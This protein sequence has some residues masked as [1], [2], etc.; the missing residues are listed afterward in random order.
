M[1]ETIVGMGI[2]WVILVAVFYF[3]PFI[4]ANQ[5][6]H[7]HQFIIFILNL[8]LGGTGVIWV[9]LLLYAILSENTK[10]AWIR[11]GR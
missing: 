10:K 8:I 2:L 3:L 5:R 11:N 9:L 7:R 1:F 6:R 4:I